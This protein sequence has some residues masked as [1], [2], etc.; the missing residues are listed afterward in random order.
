MGELFVL[1]KNITSFSLI[2]DKTIIIS[3]KEKENDKNIFRIFFL[4]PNCQFFKK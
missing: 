1:N 3:L 2:M 4:A